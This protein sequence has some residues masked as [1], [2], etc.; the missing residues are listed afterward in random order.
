MFWLHNAGCA[1]HT[2]SGSQ[3]PEVTYEFG[4]PHRTTVIVERK[5]GTQGGQ[6][7]LDALVGV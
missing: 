4:T 3:A 1:G 6:M 7:P 5:M 2:A